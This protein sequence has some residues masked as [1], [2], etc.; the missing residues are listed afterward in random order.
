MRSQRCAFTTPGRTLAD[1]EIDMVVQP[2]KVMTPEEFCQVEGPAIALDGAVSGPPF[3]DPAGPYA[4]YNH[5][6]SVDRYSTRSSCEQAFLDVGQGLWIRM[7]RNGRPAADV[8]VNDADEDV[9]TALW[10]LAN[11][12]RINEPAVRRLVEV[13][14]ILDVLAATWCPEWAEIDGM[15]AHV[16][17]VYAPCHD[18][19]R[20]ARPADERSLR[21]II[22]E[23]AARIT[24]HVNG[25]GGRRAPGKE[26][27]PVMRKG[28]IAVVTE[29]GPYA[30]MQ[31]RLDGLETVI[32][33]RWAGPVRV[34]SITKTTPWSK[35][36]LNEVYRKLNDLDA[37]PPGDR[38]GGSD[39]VGGSPRIRGT[40]LSL[41]TILEVV[42]DS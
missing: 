38:W 25:L 33:E 28:T 3:R 41:A 32:S 18:A 21:A 39:L 4:S 12:R 26:Y 13:E 14:G 10:V 35:T 7:R 36:D 29:H 6:E 16:A 11:P 23:V 20:E 1:P 31:E 5:H 37:C 27:G 34:V 17:W 8:Y 9:C 40:A 42:A 30:R 2:G 19:R 24:A 15:L 22:E